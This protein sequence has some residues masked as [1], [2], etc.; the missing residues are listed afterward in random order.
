MNYANVETRSACGA[1]HFCWKLNGRF[2]VNCCP[3]KKHVR[4]IVQ[5]QLWTLSKEPAFRPFLSTVR[6]RLTVRDEA[7]EQGLR[8]S[9]E[10]IWRIRV[11]HEA[12]W[13]QKIKKRLFSDQEHE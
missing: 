9:T 12:F 8:D 4:N 5:V 7:M 11:R 2:L 6:P 10:R 1:D 13:K 3:Q